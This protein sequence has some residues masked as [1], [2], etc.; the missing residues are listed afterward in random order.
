MKAILIIVFSVLGPMSK[1]AEAKATSDFQTWLQVSPNYKFSENFSLNG[2]AQWRAG[3]GNADLFLTDVNGARTYSIGT[4]ELGVSTLSRTTPWMT[5]LEWRPWI[6]FRRKDMLGSV[7]WTNRLRSEF[8]FLSSGGDPVVRFRYFTGFSLDPL[9][10]GTTSLRGFVD[11]E[12]FIHANSHV[13]GPSS[14][15]DQN[16]FRIGVGWKLSSALR[17]DLCY[18]NFWLKQAAGNLIVHIPQLSLVINLSDL[19]DSSEHH[20]G[21]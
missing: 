15:F 11:D 18:L 21:S 5:A 9:F 20:Q 1:P 7:A 13:G 8:R 2:L 17:F 14:G 10:A 19:T 4:A 6:G 3:R 16:R 12:L